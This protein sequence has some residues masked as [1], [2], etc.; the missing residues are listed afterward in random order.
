MEEEK[1]DN[2][3]NVDQHLKVIKETDPNDASAYLSLATAYYKL[4]SFKQALKCCFR[5]I[6]FDPSNANAWKQHG[7]CW[8]KLNNFEMAAIAFDTAKQ[9]NPEN[10]I[11]DNEYDESYLSKLEQLKPYVESFDTQFKNLTDARDRLFSK[12]EGS[13]E[14]K[15]DKVLQCFLGGEIFG[16]RRECKYTNVEYIQQLP[17]SPYVWNVVLQEF[18]LEPR[19]QDDKLERLQIGELVDSDVDCYY[20]RISC[21]SKSGA[22]AWVN[23]GYFEPHVGSESPFSLLNEHWVY[24]KPT[25]K[26][27]SD[28]IQKT[29]VHHRIPSHIG[30]VRSERPRAIVISQ[31]L[32]SE[33]N[34]IKQAISML[35]IPCYLQEEVLKSHV[36]GLYDGHIM[37]G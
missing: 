37:I 32:E 19:S 11:M 3:S 15:Q 30:D 34:A 1:H 9:I 12:L 21:V 31:H 27:I 2:V 26:H 29:I 16:Y 33:S 24:G 8:M 18:M 35:D 22:V 5:S 4:Q 7:L 20:I 10:K 17:K 28:A 13:E 6:E 36:M 14:T 25:A 23:G